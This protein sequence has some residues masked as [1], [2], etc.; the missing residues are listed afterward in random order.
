[1]G[2]G[3]RCD[4]AGALRL[5]IACR[6]LRQFL[7]ALREVFGECAIEHAVDRTM[8]EGSERRESHAVCG[9]HPG[10]GMDEDVRNAKRVGDEAGMLSGGAAEGGGGGSAPV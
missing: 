7:R 4:I 1:M 5:D 6:V 10:K 9:K 2:G 3:L 8:A